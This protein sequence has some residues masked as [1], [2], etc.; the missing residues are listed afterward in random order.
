MAAP[1]GDLPLLDA[2]T[3]VDRQLWDVPRFVGSDGTI[4]FFHRVCPH[5]GPEYSP[6]MEYG[7]VGSDY[8]FY[9]HAGHG[10]LRDTPIALRPGRPPYPARLRQRE[11]EFLK[12]FDRWSLHPALREQQFF[13]G[14]E[15]YALFFS[16][17]RETWPAMRSIEHDQEMHFGY[18][19]GEISDA[20]ISVGRWTR[21]KSWPRLSTEYPE[22]RF[23]LF[24]WWEGR[25]LAQEKRQ[26]LALQKQLLSGQLPVRDRK[27]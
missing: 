9:F 6:S 16:K 14:A 25:R 18:H 21:L 13:A 4:L 24:R 17:P 11:S 7:L 12:G 26:W 19:L 23:N 3:P 2:R 27:R 1:E 5:S 20:P 10:T 22:P 15:A 8:A